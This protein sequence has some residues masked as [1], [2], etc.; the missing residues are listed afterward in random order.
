M[1]ANL[2]HQKLR[3]KLQTQLSNALL[4][5]VEI[6]RDVVAIDT[7][8]LSLSIEVD[9]PIIVGDRIVGSIQA[10]GKDYTGQTLS[11]GKE[12]KYVDYALHQENVTGFLSAA[13]PTILSELR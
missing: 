10:G 1:R 2:N 13:I 9:P 6:S 8:S 4:A 11:T 5:G 12:G 7:S 3:L